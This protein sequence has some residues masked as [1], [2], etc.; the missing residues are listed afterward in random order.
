LSSWLPFCVVTV[1]GHVGH[2]VD[3]DVAGLGMGLGTGAIG[4]GAASASAAVPNARANTSAG[5]VDARSQLV[6]TDDTS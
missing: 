5:I 1:V 6:D 2:V 3:G 4:A